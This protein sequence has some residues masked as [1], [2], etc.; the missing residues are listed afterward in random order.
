MVD[1]VY[2]VERTDESGGVHSMWAPSA[3]N[4]WIECPLSV[5]QSQALPTPP[6]HPAAIEGTLA[7]KFG[8]QVL[9]D[10]ASLDDI[11]DETMRAGVEIYTDYVEGVFE[12]YEDP[13]YEVEGRVVLE[14]LIPGG[15]P[16]Y[17]SCFGSADFFIYDEANKQIP[18]VVDFKY[19]RHPV[20]AKDNLQLMLYA[21]GLAEDI[22]HTGK[23]KLT[24]VQP[25]AH[26]A[27]GPIRTWTVTGKQLNELRLRVRKVLSTAHQSK[28]VAG[29][30]CHYC[31]LAPTC[32]VKNAE[33]QQLAG[34]EFSK[35][36]FKP[37][38]PE[39]MDDQQVALIVEH[40]KA[41]IKWLESVVTS[42]RSRVKGGEKIAGTKLVRNSGRNGWKDDKTFLKM[43]RAL[44]IDVEDAYKSSPKGMGDIKKLLKDM[45]EDNPDELIAEYIVKTEGGISLVSENDGRQEYNSAAI[46][47]A[48]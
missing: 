1:K 28:K 25:R 22:G 12:S 27:D 6:A 2:Q 21:L 42:A 31:P 47:F 13:G 36:E 45:Y 11:E 46:D 24:I 43:T 5:I 10:D 29:D 41:I 8:E 17:W 7:H 4:R 20:E 35:S 14:Q 40:H 33:I 18:E 48:D 9:L 23:V 19:G 38:I 16:S 44:G 39:S 32:E 3:C 37:M 26:H 34:Y 15:S 30:H